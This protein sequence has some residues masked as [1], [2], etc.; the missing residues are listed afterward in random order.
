MTDL[1]VMT[2]LFI[3]DLQK[4]YGLSDD[5]IAAHLKFILAPSATIIEIR[6]WTNHE[7]EHV[8]S[9]ENLKNWKLFQPFWCLFRANRAFLVV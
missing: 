7:K 8:S 1:F 4:K 9:A 3:R 5:E 6:T 2:E